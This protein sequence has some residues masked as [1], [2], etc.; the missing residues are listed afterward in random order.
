MQF[1]IPDL[2]RAAVEILSG[3]WESEARP[4]GVAAVIFDSEQ[5]FL[6]GVDEEH[7]LY[8]HYNPLPGQRLPDVLPQG[9]VAYPGGLFFE[10]AS[11]ND[12]LWALAEKVASAVQAAVTRDPEPMPQIPTPTTTAE[13]GRA[14]AEHGPTLSYRITNNLWCHSTEHRTPAT[15]QYMVSHLGFTLP[16]TTTRPPPPTPRESCTT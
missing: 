11:A 12:G 1:S 9:V 3:G 14:H 16:A 6:L 2:A 8:L 5:A 15:A 4:W 13:L 10:G 7:A